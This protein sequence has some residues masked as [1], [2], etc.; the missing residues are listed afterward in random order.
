MDTARYLDVRPSPMLLDNLDRP[1][2]VHLNEGEVWSFPAALDTVNPSLVQATLAAEDQRFYN[3]WGV[4]P[5]AIIRAAFQ[6]AR[7]GRVHSGASTITMQLVKLEDGR[8]RS[9][10]NKMWQMGQAM[11]LELR[12]DKDAILEAYLNRAPYGLNL[13]GCD[14]A[15]QRY[16]GKPASTL[17]VSEAALLASLPKA[18]TSLMPLRNPRDARRRR[19]YVL[20]RMADLDY[21]SDEAAA[22][23]MADPTAVA[24]HDFPDR[25]PH[26]AMAIREETRQLGTI[27]THLDAELQSG[28]EQLVATHVASSGGEITNG[29][30]I[31][32]EAETARVIAR[33]GSADFYDTPGGGQVD[34]VRSPRSPGST[35]K[36][37]A[38]GLAIEGHKLFESEVLY[39]GPLDYGRYAPENFANTYSGL[40]V[41]HNALKTSL[42]VPAVTVM[43]RV[44]VGAFQEFLREGGLTTVSQPPDHYGL[45][46]VLG[47][48][49]ATLEEVAALYCA[50]ANLGVYRP[51]RVQHDGQPAAEKRLLRESTC[52]RLY[53]MLEQPLPNTG[54]P[55]P[56]QSG[57]TPRLCWKTGTST[58]LRD[59]W[60]FVFN[61]HY[62]VGVW[63]GN[64]DGRPSPYLVGGSSALPL[65]GRMFE[66][67]PSRPTPPWPEQS[68]GSIRLAVCAR[69]GLP[70][71]AHCP[72]KRSI[73][74]PKDE[75]INRRCA[76]HRP[77]GSGI[78]EVWPASALRWD[79]SAIQPPTAT[80]GKAPGSNVASAL[81]ILSPSSGSEYVLTGLEGGDKIALRSSHDSGGKIFWFLDGRHVATAQPG[82]QPLLPLSAGSHRLTCMTAQGDRASVT[83]VVHDTTSDRT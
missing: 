59:A 64:N 51:L 53:A 43:G 26:F 7:E 46:L 42:N 57:V 23:A 54:G 10:L 37:F 62:V 32:V 31:V 70:A 30:A 33:V 36:P 22:R 1:L 41:A 79:L 72:Q 27:R 35:L 3:H 58:G 6:N 73:W 48:C 80:K 28:L 19:D 61:R 14:A 21:L 76:V 39:D 9:I 34:A 24:W 49:E 65:A 77:T 15:A 4:D 25:A 47:N 2:Y 82:H 60:A 66:A 45:G 44:G 74:I 67:L 68:D 83:F 55:A 52:L 69:S 71:S 20:R 29:A 16:F 13:M 78:A 40:V 75:Y 38:Y 50:V 63:L 17:T 56:S 18:P 5:W 12:E 8:Q 81:Q 11:R